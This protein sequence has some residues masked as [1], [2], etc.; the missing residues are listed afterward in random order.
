MANSYQ[1]ATSDGTMTFIDIS[2][3]YLDRSEISVYFDDIITTAWSW[4]GTE[5]KRILFSPAVPN[6]TVVEVRRLTDASQLRHEFS[7]GAAFTAKTLDEDLKQALH[8]AQEASEANLVGDFFTDI[9]MHGFRVYN[10]G[11]A[12]DDTDV[13]TLGQARADSTTAVA[14]A[15]A[16][17]AA[18]A[19]A[20]AS[21]ANAAATAT[22]LVNGLK[23]DLLDPVTTT[24]GAG[25]VGFNWNTNYTDP[26]TIGG[27][28]RVIRN[29]RSFGNFAG[30]GTTDDG[31]VWAAA[32][33]S[34]ASVIDARGV[35][36]KCLSTI[37]IQTGQTWLLSGAHIRIVGSTFRL[38]SAVSVSDWNLVGPF[39]VTGDL[40]TNPGESVTSAAVYVEDCR[41]FRVIEPTGVSIRGAVIDSRPGGSI[42]PRAEHGIFSQ[43]RG[44]GC[45][46]GYRDTAGA[47]AEYC[48]ILAPH[49]ENMSAAGIQTAA[50]NITVIG[51]QLV[52]NYDGL[53]LRN[54]SNN[55]HGIISGVNINHNTNYALH[56]LSVTNGETIIGCHFYGNGTSGQG[57]IFLE[58]SK[59]IVIS[60]G[61]VD[62]WVYNDSGA[63]SGTNYLREN[64]CPGDYLGVNITN[65]VAGKEQLRVIGNYGP[66]V[67]Y[68]GLT[69]NTPG[70]AWC[71]T[72]R[73][74]ASAAL[75]SGT[76]TNLTFSA[77][78]GG[79]R[80][81]LY[82]GG[83][84][85]VAAGEG[86]WYEFEGNQIF[87]ASTITNTSSYLEVQV[88]PAAGAYAAVD[89]F[90]P[91]QMFTG[92]GGVVNIPHKSVFHLAAGDKVRLM[93]SITGTGTITHGRTSWRCWAT[94]KRVA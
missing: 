63:N 21:A 48:T 26:Q 27:A 40:V 58:D 51:G 25:M 10:V 73:V 83:E 84:F 23:A 60:G 68:S 87:S 11:T 41:R 66:G 80:L 28:L 16:A 55:A 29:I 74:T 34:G 32:A 91:P 64:F 54:G 82:A 22:V 62:C 43:P 53:R 3:D 88:K 19:A 78:T 76:L 24:E 13:L 47:G 20:A 67:L 35:H 50:G 75:T 71:L 30:D 79:D 18:A 52:D 38:F 70:T 6:G 59:K 42:V 90:I 15:D 46:W 36:S 37:N 9:N 1:R 44:N 61:V 77:A 65:V 69:I 7:T 81:T 49:F 33:A 45:V 4:S 14:A 12:V 56:A 8:M 2:I 39:K 89:V 31:A 17:S 72:E 5:D 93:G 57:P 86:G 92:G 94:L 85:T